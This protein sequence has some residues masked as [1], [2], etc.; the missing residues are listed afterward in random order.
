VAASQ[1]DKF[2]V[3]NVEI[4]FKLF[5]NSFPVDWLLQRWIKLAGTR[6]RTL[7]RHKHARTRRC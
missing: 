1:H 7:F 5:C 2:A 3:N 6:T 4:T